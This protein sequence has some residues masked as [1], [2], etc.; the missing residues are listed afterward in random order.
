MKE[1]AHNLI[2]PDGLIKAFLDHPPS[3]FRS[4]MSSHGVPVFSAPFDLLT[5]V[6]PAARKRLERWP[7]A[8]IWRRWLTPRTCFVGATCT[9]YAPLPQTTPADFL[10]GLLREAGDDHAFVIVKDIPT[11]AALVGEAAWQHSRQLLEA[12]PEH[13]FVLVEG[14]ALAYVAVDFADTEEFL[15]RMPKSRRKDLKRKLKSR[16]D[17]HIETLQTGDARFFDEALLEEYYALYLQVYD[18]SDI[19]FDRL[20]PAFFRAL[21]QDAQTPGVVFAYEADGELIGYNLCFV[22]NG[23][24][25]DKYVGFRY[26]QAREHNLYMVSWFQNLEYAL[27]HGLTHYVAG[28]TDPE[29]KRHLGASFTMTQHAVHVRNPLLRNMLRPFKRFFESDASWH[30]QTH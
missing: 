1:A 26:P 10:H 9:E 11:D 23:M 18:Q 25:L 20:T 19:H 13:D 21:L 24:L 28:W 22:H 5:T 7:F 16:V 4:W 6:D 17:L 3:G 8:R 30:D 14:Q 15:T 29:I 12:C 2:E 27:A